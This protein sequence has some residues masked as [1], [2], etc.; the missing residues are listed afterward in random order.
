MKLIYKNGYGACYR[1]Y[2]APNPD[3]ILQLVVETV[4]IFMSRKDLGHLLSIV[5][6][7]PGPCDCPE[8]EGGEC[9]KI[10]Y[11]GHL[12][13]F[14]LK[15]D[16]MALELMEDLIEGTLFILDMDRTLEQ[17]RIK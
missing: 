7:P 17:Y 9:G 3:C 4:G 11:R 10:W 12:L 13:D 15:M 14:Y 2:D 5:R 8:C 1:V 6:E 16:D